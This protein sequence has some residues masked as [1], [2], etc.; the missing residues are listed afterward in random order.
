MAAPRSTAGA[1]EGS[2]TADPAA[3][4]RQLADRRAEAF[5][6]NRPDLLA[7]VY[8]SP[9]LLAQDVSQLSSRVPPGCGLTGLR[10]RYRDVRVTGSGPQSLE[11]QVTATQPPASLVCAGAVRGHTEAAGPTGLVLRLVRAG[12]GFPHRLATPARGMMAAP[13]PS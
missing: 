11:L 6:G 3:V 12:D 8:R 7:E 10:T 1:A 5:A 13:W 2:G 9:A 4:L